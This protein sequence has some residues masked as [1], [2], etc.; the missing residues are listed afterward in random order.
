MRW[1]WHIV[2]C[3]VAIVA[4]SFSLAV[5]GGVHRAADQAEIAL[6]PDAR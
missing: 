3:G 5:L 2:A 4:L 1:N 6:Q